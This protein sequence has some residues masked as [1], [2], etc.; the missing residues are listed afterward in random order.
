MSN[1][2]EKRRESSIKLALYVN[3]ILRW[4]KFLLY[5]FIGLSIFAIILSLII[6]KTFSASALIL[7]PGGN[8]AFSSFLPES[9]TKG[10]GG[11]MGSALQDQGEGTD[12]I[13]AILNSRSLAVNAIDHFHLKEKWGSPTDE[14]AVNTFHS[15]VGI[16]VDDEGMIRITTNIKT[17]YFHPQKNEQATRHLAVDLNKYLLDQLDQKYIRLQTQKARYEGTV[18]QKRYK[19]NQ[20]DL[21]EAEQKL[22]AFSEKNGMISLPEQ[23]KATVETAAQLE[24]NIIINQIEMDAL[25]QTMNEKMPEL[26]KKRIHIKEMKDKLRNIRFNESMNDSLNIFPTF[27]KAPDLV[28]KYERLKR[29]VEIQNI[30]Y[31]YLTQQYEQVKLQE[32]KAT[33]S[34]QFIDQ[35]VLPTKRSSPTRSLLCIAIVLAG[36]MLTV[37]FMFGYEYYETHYADLMDHINDAHQNTEQ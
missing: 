9:M 27:K 26:R 3:V 5:N 8:S 37:A 10:L 28:L 7:P 34:L 21:A 17:D 16:N 6:P 25:R 14:D 18:I 19:Q 36:M 35:P 15:Q 4:K 31:K 13:L 33:P 24:S 32:S 22:K 20:Q 1:K 11:V 23:V 30:I 12:K 29:N 2:P